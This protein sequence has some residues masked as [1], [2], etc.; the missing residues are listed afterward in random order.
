MHTHYDTLGIVPA[1]DRLAINDAYI[2]AVTEVMPSQGFPHGSMKWHQVCA[3]IAALTQAMQ[4]LSHGERRD[5]YDKKLL[6]AAL[7]CSLCKGKGKILDDG[8]GP[9][10]SCIA[11]RGTGRGNDYA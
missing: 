4:V 7:I 11:C 6:A 5:V 3:R 8:F 10:L 9:K 1:S 2:S